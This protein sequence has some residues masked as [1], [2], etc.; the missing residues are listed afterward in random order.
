MFVDFII[1]VIELINKFFSYE[2]SNVQKFLTK[3][4]RIKNQLVVEFQWS[5]KGQS[6]GH[7]G[8]SV[9]VV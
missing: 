4:I 6:R 9:W 7:Y 3:H 2:I 1:I 8:C 5:P